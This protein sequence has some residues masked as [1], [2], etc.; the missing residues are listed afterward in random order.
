MNVV[1]AVV[2]RLA[3]SE[4]SN[5]AS[6]QVPARSFSPRVRTRSQPP[7]SAGRH[8]SSGLAGPS[9]MRPD[10]HDLLS[11]DIAGMV[12]KEG[13]CLTIGEGRVLAA[14]RRPKSPRYLFPLAIL[15]P[16]ELATRG[17]ASSGAGAPGILSEGRCFEDPLAGRASISPA[18]RCFNDDRASSC[19]SSKEVASINCGMVLQEVEE[20]IPKSPSPC[21]TAGQRPRS[22][23]N[24][25]Q[26][27]RSPPIV[28]ASP[29]MQACDSAVDGR[30]A[31]VKTARRAACQARCT[32]LRENGA[33]GTTDQ[34]EFQ[35]E[36]SS[37]RFTFAPGAQCS[38]DSSATNCGAEEICAQEFA[39]V[40]RSSQGFTDGHRPRPPESGPSTLLQPRGLEPFGRADALDGGVEAAGADGVPRQWALQE[41]PLASRPSIAPVRQ[42]FNNARDSAD[43]TFEESSTDCSLLLEEAHASPPAPKARRGTTPP[44]SRAPRTYRA[45]YLSGARRA[46]AGVQPLL[47][48]VAEGVAPDQLEDSAQ[49]GTSSGQGNR[50]EVL[51]T[52]RTRDDSCTL[53]DHTYSDDESI[54]RCSDGESVSITPTLGDLPRPRAT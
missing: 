17:G 7:R 43:S 2:P 36:S 16:A 40:R 53:S 51:D 37:D 13:E 10:D 38:D 42:C 1:K 47:S 12:S 30:E 19:C 32:A 50:R 9:S 41:E 49:S 52:D 54:G 25:Y 21:L 39:L 28:H 18:R 45:S 24:Q 48:S 14:K 20:L 35:V 4:Q 31:R 8:E 34:R 22:P 3:A 6:A 44:R 11:H 5:Q 27:L 23:R 29:S 26:H 15:Q 33:S 46:E